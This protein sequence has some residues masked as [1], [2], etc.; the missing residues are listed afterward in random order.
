VQTCF[1]AGLE[2][3]QLE[4]A[5]DCL[6]V[7]QLYALARQMM[8]DRGLVPAESRAFAGTRVLVIDEP[9]ISHDGMRLNG[10]YASGSPDEITLERRAETLLHELLHAWQ[11]KHGVSNSGSHPGW[12]TNGYFAA[13]SAFRAAAHPLK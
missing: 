13:D 9:Y 7:E 10:M 12:D 5:V 3:V 2:R 6:A 11:E 1:V 8:S 4:F